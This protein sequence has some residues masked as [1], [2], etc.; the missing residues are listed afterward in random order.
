MGLQRV[1][2]ALRLFGS[3]ERVPRSIRQ[4]ESFKFI[5]PHFIPP[6]FAGNCLSVCRPGLSGLI[7]ASGGGLLHLRIVEAN[8]ETLSPFPCTRL[9]CFMLF[10]VYVVPADLLCVIGRLQVKV[11][12]ILMRLEWVLLSAACLNWMRLALPKLVSSPFSGMNFL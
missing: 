3:G 10:A 12:A 11:N 7:L 6:T 1:L 5:R 9:R 4:H 8:V 2:L